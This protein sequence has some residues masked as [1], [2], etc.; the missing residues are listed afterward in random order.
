MRPENS[1]YSYLEEMVRDF[2]KHGKG[3]VDD[4]EKQPNGSNSVPESARSG[5]SHHTVR[6][7]GPKVFH[8]P[9]TTSLVARCPTP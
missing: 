1:K 2:L 3:Y 5:L 7:E 8:R 6:S 9:K 4:V